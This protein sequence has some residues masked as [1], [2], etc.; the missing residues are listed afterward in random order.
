[1]FC[2][3]KPCEVLSP[4]SKQT[5][6]L[7]LRHLRK[8]DVSSDPFQPSPPRIHIFVNMQASNEKAD[9]QHAREAAVHVKEKT[10]EKMKKDLQDSIQQSGLS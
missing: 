8:S 9:Q 3:R 1:M 2:Y 10:D 4:R 5:A 6:K 7:N